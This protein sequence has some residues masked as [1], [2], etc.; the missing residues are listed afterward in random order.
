MSTISCSF[1]DS[2]SV[3]GVDSVERDEYYSVCESDLQRL[4]S[5]GMVQVELVTEYVCLGCGDVLS[6]DEV[7]WEC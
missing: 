3:S 5:E 6:V 4:V 7:C 1:C 2:L